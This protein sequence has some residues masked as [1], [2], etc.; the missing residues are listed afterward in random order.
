MPD[1]GDGAPIGC[2]GKIDFLIVISRDSNMR[3]RQEQLVLAFPQFIAAIQSKFADFDYHIMVVTGDDGWGNNN[4]TQMCPTPACKIGEPCCPLTP[5][6]DGGQPCCTVPQY[7]CQDLDLVTQCDRTWGAGEVFPAGTDAP[8][9]PCSIEGDR[10]YLVK[11]QSDLEGAP[12]PLPGERR[13]R[14]LRAGVC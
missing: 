8:N 7:P 4:C 12:V 10:R 3:F 5:N 9:K 6:G 2:N 1:F 14:R 11:G 13:G